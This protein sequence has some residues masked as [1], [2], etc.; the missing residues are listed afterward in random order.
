MFTLVIAQRLGLQSD[1]TM[2]IAIGEGILLTIVLMLLAE[3]YLFSAPV[4]AGRAP[5]G[6]APRSNGTTT[7]LE[8]DERAGSA[9]QA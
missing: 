2:A 6:G 7:A 4:G 5:V 8:P 1:W 3:R 9:A